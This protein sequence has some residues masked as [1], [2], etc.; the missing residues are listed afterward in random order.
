MIFNPVIP[1]NYF[2]CI[3]A[4]LSM[5]ETNDNWTINFFIALVKTRNNF[6]E[7]SENIN[8]T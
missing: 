4:Y 6:A 8:L 7:T 2:S 1:L 5:K 3:V